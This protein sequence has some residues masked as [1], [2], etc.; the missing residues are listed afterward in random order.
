MIAGMNRSAFVLAPLALCATLTCASGPARAADE[1]AASAA[2]PGMSKKELDAAR[3]RVEKDYADKVKECR[4]R[5]VVTSCLE[6]ARD[7]RIR[8]LRP[9]DR[10]EHQVNAE[11]RL[12]KGA[13]ARERVEEKEREAAADEARRKTESVRAAEQPVTVPQQPASHTPR[14]NPELHQ[15]R[16]AQQEAAAQAEA[17]KRREAAADRRKEASDRQRKAHEVQLKRAEKQA[18]AASAVSPGG[19]KTPKPAPVHL[20]TPSASDIQSLPKR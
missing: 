18:S 7:E 8:L 15:R 19:L 13:A 10:A 9:L 6:D 3:A 5:F 1:S 20:P 2:A 12:R 14:A 16:Q 11:E 4:Q 17:A